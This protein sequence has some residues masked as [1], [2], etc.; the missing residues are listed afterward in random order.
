MD[1]QIINAQLKFNCC[2]DWDSMATTTGGRNCQLCQKKVFDF[3]NSTQNDLDLIL[4]ENNSN[5]C[6]RFTASQAS[7]QPRIIPVW[8]K[9]V[10]AA[11]VLVG[12]NLFNIKAIAQNNVPKTDT[13]AY[14]S[15][16]I[17]MGEIA[18]INSSPQFIGGKE[19]LDIFLKKHLNYKGRN[20]EVRLRFDVDTSGKVKNLRVIASLDASS[21][22][23]ALRVIKLSPKWAPATLQGKPVNSSF[24]LPVKFQN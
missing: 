11:M 19:A 10:S 9:W 8:K 13:N 7:V 3:T 6:G 12:F 14:H 23:E 22:K 5:I 2:A 21:D 16:R 17:L 1:K 4:S 15:G 20:G 18:I 24:T